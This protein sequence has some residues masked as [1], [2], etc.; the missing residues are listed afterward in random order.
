MAEKEIL[1]D[2]SVDYVLITIRNF[3][4]KGKKGPFMFEYHPHS[5][6]LRGGSSAFHGITHIDG[7][8]FEKEFGKA[9]TRKLLALCR[10][11]GRKVIKE[12][13]NETFFFDET[14]R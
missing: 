6:F 3:E 10:R 13:E 5:D 4:Y 12:V 7:G 11:I 9:K 2:A 8:M 14:G 1:A